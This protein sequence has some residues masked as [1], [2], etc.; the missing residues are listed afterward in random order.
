[1]KLLSSQKS[2]NPL[3]GKIKTTF[4]VDVKEE[5]T[6]DNLNASRNRDMLY[7]MNNVP[8]NCYEFKILN[9]ELPHCF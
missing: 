6:A 7:K 3:Y 5:D 4:L 2:S 9:C 1:M 8:I